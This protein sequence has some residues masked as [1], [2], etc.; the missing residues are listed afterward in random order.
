[1]DSPAEDVVDSRSNVVGRKRA[2]QTSADQGREV[3][4]IDSSSDESASQPRKRAKPSSNESAKV[5]VDLTSSPLPKESID[6]LTSEAKVGSPATWNQGVQSGLRTSFK[7]KK[8][9]PSQSTPLKQP[10]QIPNSTL[11]KSQ[12]R[13]EQKPMTKKQ[14][15]KLG[16]DKQLALMESY[17]QDVSTLIDLHGWPVPEE[18]QQSCLKFIGEGLTFYPTPVRKDQPVGRYSFG[19]GDVQLQELYSEEGKPITS[20]DI[21]YSDILLS[22]MQNNEF[23]G[24]ALPDKR[25]RAAVKSYLSYFYNHIPQKEQFISSLVAEAPSPIEVLK[26]AKKGPQIL[27][28]ATNHYDE[29]ASPAITNDGSVKDGAPMKQKNASTSKSITK[30]SGEESTQVAPVLVTN[31]IDPTRDHTIPTEAGPVQMDHGSSDSVARSEMEVSS[32]GGVAADADDDHEFEAAREM[33]LRPSISPDDHAAILKYFP[34]TDGAI[35]RKCLICGSSGHDRSVCSDNACSSCGSKGD[36]LT[37]ACPR[38]T[39]CGKCREVGHQTSQCPEKL[40]A[41]RDD[42]KCNTCQSTSHLEDQCHVIWRSF[43]PDPNEIKKVRNILAFCYFCGRPGHFGPECGLYRGKPA[44]GG[45]SWSTSNMEK[46]LDGPNSY[47]DTLSLGGNDYSIPNRGKK[48]FTIKG[49]ANDPINL[50]DSDDDEGF[51]QPKVNTAPRNGHIQFSQAGA[52]Q[53]FN[54]APPFQFQGNT[55]GNQNSRGP[56]GNRGGRGGRRGGGSGGSGGN[57]EKN[58]PKHKSGNNPPRGGGQSRGKA[59]RGRG[60]GGPARGAPRGRR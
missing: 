58:K 11:E 24:R 51:I 7:S 2:L 39:I 49:K 59:Y 40:R 33:G 57:A 19:G 34:S 52:M 44:S 35:L 8:P 6:T 32:E 3:V 9:P 42:V 48:G 10:E 23:F 60:G 4:T 25:A 38:T 13:S 30:S 5:E 18:F 45:K 41:V 1:M 46:F 56:P 16:E 14:F 26:N 54:Q 55:S 53:S 29:N 12:G 17:T 31:A 20:K 36:H 37:P 15:N 21:T 27:A 43:L 28:R 22:L 50:D 47:D